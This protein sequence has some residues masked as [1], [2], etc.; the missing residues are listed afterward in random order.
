MAASLGGI[1]LAYFL[2][3]GHRRFAESLA[4]SGLGSAVHRFWLAGWDF[5]RL[6]DTLLVRPFCQLAWINRDDIVDSPYRGA[7]RLSLWSYHALRRSQT[8]RL[9]WYATAIATGSV[10]IAAIALLL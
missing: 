10:V 4:R 9:R 7:A 8:G 3:T 2:F 6:Y 5:D 1:G